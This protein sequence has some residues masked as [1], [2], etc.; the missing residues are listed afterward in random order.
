MLL[1]VWFVWLLW[2]IEEEM[3]LVSSF[4]Y[5]RGKDEGGGRQAYIKIPPTWIAKTG[6]PDN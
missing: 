6:S 3:M 5:E 4:R 2:C 1:G